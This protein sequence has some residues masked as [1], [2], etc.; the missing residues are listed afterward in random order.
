VGWGQGG[1]RRASERGKR[2]TDLD[3]RHD[4]GRAARLVDNFVNVEHEHDGHRAPDDKV[5]GG[6]SHDPQHPRHE[7]RSPRDHL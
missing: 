2:E 4:R 1:G 3:I 6:R 7:D 5:D